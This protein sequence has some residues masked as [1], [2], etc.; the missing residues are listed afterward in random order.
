MLSLR[1]VLKIQDMHIDLG[2]IILV[3]NVCESSLLIVSIVLSLQ[4]QREVV[5][6]VCTQS[7]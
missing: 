5:F 3:L 2:Y 6:G 1:D 4:H 7:T